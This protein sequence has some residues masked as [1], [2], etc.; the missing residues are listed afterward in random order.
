MVRPA[1]TAAEP[2]RRNLTGRAE[3]P[4]RVPPVHSVQPIHC[5]NQQNAIAVSY[6]WP[7]SQPP[8]P[9]THPQQVPGMEATVV[10]AQHTSQLYVLLLERPTSEFTQS[11]STWAHEVR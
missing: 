6:K 1:D 5:T 4:P 9:D 8:T 11:L 10:Q 2:N 3:P 7:Q